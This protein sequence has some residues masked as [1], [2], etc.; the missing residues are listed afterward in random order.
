[1]DDVTTSEIAKALSGR[2]T[3]E[4]RG[5]KE[6]VTRLGGRRLAPSQVLET[7]KV[8]ISAPAENT[9]IALEDDGFQP[10]DNIGVSPSWWSMLHRELFREDARPAAREIEAALER[11]HP[12]AMLHSK[13]TRL[14]DA[15]LAQFL[16]GEPFH[17]NAIRTA[18]LLLAERILSGAPWPEPVKIDSCH[19]DDELVAKIRE[20]L[21]VLYRFVTINQVHYPTRLRLRIALSAILADPWTT[22][23]LRSLAHQ[24]IQA[25]VHKGQDWLDTLPAVAPIDLSDNPM[26]IIIDAVSP[27][28]WLET[29]DQIIIELGDMQTSW[30]RL[31]VPPKTAPA[32]AALFGFSGDALDEFHAR[33]I[34][35]HQVRGNDAYGLKDILPEFS[36]EK[37]EV[38]RVSLVDEAAHAALLRLAEMP[39]AICSFLEKELARLQDICTRQH[40]RLILTTDHGL[41]LTARGLSHGAGGV[42]EQAVFRVQ[43]MPATK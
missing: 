29:L 1:L 16:T 19:V 22:P 17:T 4:R 38:V 25:I 6:L 20:R 13:L 28:V 40:R 41:S 11:Q 30:Q 31:E 35:Y 33:G 23:D 3:I 2:V 34:D 36:T 14:D 37:P 18:W 21:N 27:D 26:V 12:A 39:A 15:S 32:V 9:V 8:W 43:W 24:K 10:A 5:L 42:F 7:V